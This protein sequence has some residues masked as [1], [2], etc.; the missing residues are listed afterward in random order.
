MGVVF[1][2]RTQTIYELGDTGRISAMLLFN[3]T[4]MGKRKLLVRLSIS[5]AHF[6]DLEVS[7]MP[8]AEIF[9]VIKTFRHPYSKN[10]NQ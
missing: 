8:G 3:L 9:C 6:Q 10:I 7:L 1:K 2:A 5:H 4:H